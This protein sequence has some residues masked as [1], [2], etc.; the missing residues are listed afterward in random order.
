MCDKLLLFF[1][2][3][4]ELAFLM[5]KWA[6]AC[7][8]H[9]MLEAHSVHLNQPA[10]RDQQHSSGCCNCAVHMLSLM[11]QV[12]GAGRRHSMLEARSV[13]INQFCHM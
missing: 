13:Y 7:K 9:S 4:M 12:G 11:T 5:C 1:D 6:E 2:S 3:A 8:P 10:M